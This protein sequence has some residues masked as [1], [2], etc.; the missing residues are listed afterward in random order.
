MKKN[1]TVLFSTVIL[2]L[3]FVAAVNAQTD[4]ALKII[5]KPTASPRDCPRSSSGTAVVRVTFDKTG[6][7]TD[8]ELVRSS[9]CS[10]F[11]SSAVDA[12]RRIKFEPAVK[13][14]E[15]V[16]VSKPVEYKYSKY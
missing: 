16:T 10:S 7:I 8:T 1:F 15:A 13:N 3:I 5:S 4:K 6:K 11:D 14:G 2:S 9:A 12:A